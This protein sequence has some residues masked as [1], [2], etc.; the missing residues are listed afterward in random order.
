MN[1]QP[2]AEDLRPN[3][4]VVTED[5]VSEALYRLATS[6]DEIAIARGDMVRAEYMVKRMK[7][8][9]MQESD[10]KSAA[11]REAE[12]MASD[13]MLD[14]IDKMVEAIIRFERLKAERESNALTVEAWRTSQA[15][16]RAARI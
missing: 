12:A 3:A 11:M 4:P 9:I 13:K 16:I 10:E 8:I 7:A 15:T 1:R 2:A 6:A 5:E 14:A